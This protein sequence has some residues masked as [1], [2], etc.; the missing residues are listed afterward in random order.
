MEDIQDDS[1]Q[2]SD[3]QQPPEIRSY[4]IQSS[5]ELKDFLQSIDGI[6]PRY[7]S[8]LVPHHY[9][10][11]TSTHNQKLDKCRA[12]FQETTQ[13]INDKFDSSLT[14]LNEYLKRAHTLRGK[15]VTSKLNEYKRKYEGIVASNAAA[16][17]KM[18][19]GIDKYRTS[20]ALIQEALE[21]NHQDMVRE[22]QQFES[23]MEEIVAARQATERQAAISKMERDLNRFR[24]LEGR[25]GSEEKTKTQD[26]IME[27]FKALLKNAKV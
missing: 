9:N 4:F 6:G 20:Q 8:V 7:L 11:S 15:A 27:S 16:S 13:G 24:E 23:D 21:R 17:K 1:S 25:L 19:A 12:D 2:P 26:E 10:S 22:V 14:W 5:R 18:K 3:T